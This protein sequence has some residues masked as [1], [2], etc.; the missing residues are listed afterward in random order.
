M[1]NKERVVDLSK[2]YVCFST[3]AVDLSR[4]VC[5][6][7]QTCWFEARSNIWGDN[8]PNTFKFAT[9]VYTCQCKC[10]I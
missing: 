8:C 2:I 7:R 10:N 4:E 1:K 6:G 3:G 9:A 5:D